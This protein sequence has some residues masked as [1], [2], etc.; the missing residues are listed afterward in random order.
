[1]IACNLVAAA[2]CA[3]FLGVPTAAQS[4]S[5]EC[6]KPPKLVSPAKFSEEA[7]QR[8][9]KK[10]IE[11]TVVFDIGEDGSVLTPK[12]TKAKTKEIA[13]AVLAA[14]KNAKYESRPGCKPVEMEITFRLKPD[15][16]Q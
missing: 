16:W 6:A 4:Q 3:A 11:A 7:R 5:K 1:M 10:K 14:V 2:V 9:A 12:V 8:F 13:E 15:D